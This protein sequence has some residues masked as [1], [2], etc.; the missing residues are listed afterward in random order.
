LYLYFINKNKKCL[1]YKKFINIFINFLIF[2]IIKNQNN[3]ALT[4]E[5]IALELTTKN[6]VK[7]RNSN[8]K[9]N[10][11]Y[12]L[13]LLLDSKPLSRIEIVLK[14]A[15]KRISEKLE[16][17]IKPTD[18][19]N[20]EF[21]TDFNAVTVTVKNAVDTSISKSNNNSSFSY[22]EKYREFEL[23]EA[24]GKYTIVKKS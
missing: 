19:E 3:Q 22:N 14:I 17:E 7:A 4:I 9:T 13:E 6:L 5:Q 24:N 12:M 16:R 10:N 18:F 11:D 2:L 15:L 20:E 21:N 8:K 23:V 1:V